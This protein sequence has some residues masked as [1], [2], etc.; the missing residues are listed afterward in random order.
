ML[1]V[2]Q[3]L[4]RLA[5]VLLGWPL[6]VLGRV[7]RVLGF[8]VALNPSFGPL[9]YL[10]IGA[11]GYLVF[12]FTLVYVA[13]PLRGVIGGH[14]MAEKLGY[15]AERWLATAVYD[16][17]KNFLGTFD[18]RLDSRRDVNYTEKTIEIGDYTANPDHKSIPVKDVPP[19]Y[20]QCLAYHEDRYIGTWLNPYGID[21]Q[22]V[23]KIPYSSIKR[24]I[25]TRRPSIGVGGST[26]PMQ[27][28]RVI[29]KTP[30]SSSEG[31]FTKLSRKMKEW[32][33]APVIYHVLT[34]GGDHTPLRQW[35]ANHIWLAQRTGGQPL[36]GVEMTARILFAKEAKDLSTAEQYVLASAVNKP[37]ILLEGNDK[38]NEVRLDRWRYITEVRAKACADKL[39]KDEATQ[40][41]VVFELIE[42]ASG[43][44]NPKVKPKMQE[45]LEHFA[46]TLAK[47]AEASPTIR[48]NALIPA[49]RLGIREEMK[50]AFGFDWRNYVRGVS[51]TFDAIENLTFREK[52][53]D[54]LGRMDKEWGPK[55]NA[56]WTLDPTKVAGAL[57]EKEG[58][59]SPHV[60]VVAANTKGEIVRY[61]EGGET[62][63][64]FGSPAARSTD[65]GS[66]ESDRETRSIASTGKMLAAIAIANENKDNADTLYTDADAP[67]KGLET[68]AK[69]G[70]APGAATEKR[71]RKSLVAFACSLNRPIEWRLAQMGQGPTEKLIG[72]FGFNMPASTGTGDA[73]PATTAAVRGYITGSPR[74]VHQMS[75]VIL[76]A[77]LEKG[78]APVR[79]PSLVRAYDFTKPEYAAEFERDR[80]T[81][82]VPNSLIRRTSHAMLKT[83]LSAPLCY[84]ANGTHHG[85]LKGLSNWCAATRPGLRLHFAKTGTSVTD[86]PHATVDTWVTGGVQFANG[87][88]YSY[89]VVVGSGTTAEPWSRSLHA[90]QLGVP[91]VAALLGDLEGHAKSHGNAALLPPGVAPGPVSAAAPPAP[92]VTAKLP[93]KTPAKAATKKVAAR[94]PPADSPQPN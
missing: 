32:W 18:P 22:G 29:Y 49:A 52:V 93:A 72:G 86:D 94:Q 67:A 30:P 78:S 1:S 42:M 80:T 81:D 39:I 19:D 55:F 15:D 40:K 6:R 41:K 74:R 79:L 62:A 37:V 73:T 77:L 8:G 46:P 66:Y 83:L 34:K 65:N 48:A 21:L 90:A 63:P 13:A 70:G 35:A 7:I 57:G 60:I 26:L 71:G 92:R 20:W 68:C 76:A 53:R 75:G 14:F 58:R 89:V 51:T 61:Y 5:E 91:L 28:A 11:L 47:R 17:N 2:F 43:P 45:A 36:H 24:T 54:E 88:A 33:L 12:A 87:A 16:S 56:G 50:H 23:L 64:Y 44:P 27:F 85:T 10:V 38:L 84:S 59:R 4:S 9:R 82:I 31:S 3:L 25:A 69:G